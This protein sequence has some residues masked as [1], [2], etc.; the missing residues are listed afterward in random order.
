MECGFIT[1]AARVQDFCPLTS[2]AR[3]S[4]SACNHAPHLRLPY[5]RYLSLHVPCRWTTIQLVRDVCKM[6]V[7]LQDYMG[8]DRYEEPHLSTDF[9]FATG[10][11]KSSRSS[12]VCPGPS[13]D[14]GS[15]ELNCF[16]S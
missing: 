11:S 14:F 4:T 15:T 9:I 16:H 13:R 8:R 5:S 10:D 12:R 7:R 1:A 2:R 6:H 3:A